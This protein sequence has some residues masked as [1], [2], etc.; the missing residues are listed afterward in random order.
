MKRL[1]V[2]TIFFISCHSVFSQE[3]R[4]ALVIGNGNYQTS[5]LANPENDARS[6]EAA[7]KEI[8]FTVIKYENVR[9]KEMAKAIDDFGNRL[10]KYDVGLFF[11]AGHG[12]QSKGFNYLIPVDADLNS[13]SDVE[14]DCISADRVLAKMEEA[15]SKINIVIFDACRDNPFERSWTR[16][17][18]SRG[19]ATMNAP[20]GS[21]IA[22]ATAPGST[23]SDGSGKNSPFTSALL[24]FINEPG[25]TLD[26]M[27]NKV[28]ADVLRKSKNQQIP[29]VASSLTGDFYLVPGST[30]YDNTQVLS[31]IEPENTGT[32]NEISIVVMPFKNL[33]GK[34]DLDY[35]VEGQQ[36]AMNTELSK[37][38]QVKPLRVVSGRTAY[39]FS[40]ATRSIPEI[41]KD[42][43]VD[44]LIEGSVLNPGDSITL[45]L[46]LIRAFPEEKQVWGQTFISD[47]RNIFKLY[48]NIAGQIAQK[49]D[50]SLTPQNL[51]NLPTP[52]QINPDTYKAYLRGMSNLRQG[53]PESIKK[54]FEYLNEAI[55]L[56]PADPFAYT[57]LAVM[58]FEMAHGPL[59]TGDA[60]MKGE[61]AAFQA[62][63]L[64]TTI[65]ETYF[66]LGETYVSS[67]WKFDEAE[68]YFKKALSINPNLALAHFYYAWTLYLFGKNKEALVEHEMARKC[69]PFDPDITAQLALM[70]IYSGQYEKGLEEALK[71]LVIMPDFQM[72][73]YALDE[74]YLNM[75]NYNEAIETAKKLVDKYP[76]WMFE[77][78]YIY[79]MTG[80]T[81]EAE[82]I[83]GQMN[84]LKVTPFTAMG[85]VVLNAALNKK[86]EAFKWLAYEPHH[87]WIAWVPVLPWFNNLYGD[88]RFDEFVKRLNLPN[89]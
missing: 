42:I 80:K 36:D 26:Q 44:F 40:N 69:D 12:V 89:K 51:I 22:Y 3:K 67:Y 58:Y 17:A 79:V 81:D 88:P 73:L 13:E 85:Q 32:D 77:L 5:I 70:Y 23:A 54:G 47:M 15:K 62:I 25:I 45:M 65:A 31:T 46:R 10:K 6:M 27:L 49:L 30:K 35:L 59:D 18:K 28:K 19:L 50:M 4:L 84:K 16:A 29:W 21:M 43:D 53:T 39:A 74:A 82:K 48:N 78:G 20:V 56:D 24:T 83:L 57:A 68:K 55:R 60:I 11:Y 2:L 9:Q 38:S 14:F 72:G 61:A 63:K 41:A 76:K 7:L 75:G 86:D 1:I 87:M 37:I 33:T 34:P 66:A 52:R 71:S 8:G 64:D